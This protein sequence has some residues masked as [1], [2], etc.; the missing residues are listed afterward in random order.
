MSAAPRP[1]RTPCSVPAI[2]V[3]TWC[4][5]CCR[6]TRSSSHPLRKSGAIT[7]ITVRLRQDRLAYY[8]MLCNVLDGNG[9]NHSCCIGRAGRH[10]LCWG[11]TTLGGTMRLDTDFASLSGD[12]LQHGV[13]IAVGLMHQQ[14][15]TEQQRWLYFRAKPF[16]RTS[17]ACLEASCQG[18]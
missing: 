12:Q 9:M 14:V 16:Q 3:C 15:W 11:A 8:G 5:A 6:G 1:R 18:A 10:Y 17:V 4:G 2:G 13:A 7:L